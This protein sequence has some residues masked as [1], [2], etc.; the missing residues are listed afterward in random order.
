MGKPLSVDVEGFFREAN[1]GIAGKARELT[2]SAPV[3]FLCECADA[4]C[5]QMVSARIEE[6]ENARAHPQRFLT[7]PGHELSRPG[8]IVEQ[9]ERFLV[10][11]RPES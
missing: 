1:E 2:F 6:Y 4:T 9:N 8:Q 5:K 10:V 7:L 3:P 11:E